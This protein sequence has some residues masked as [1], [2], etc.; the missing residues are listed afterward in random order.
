VADAA[1][2]AYNRAMLTIRVAQP[3]DRSFLLELMPRLADFS[4][5]AW[6]TVDEIAL[7]DQA[8][9]LDVLAAP[10]ADAAILVAVSDTGDRL[11]YLC[12]TTRRDYFTQR[13]HAHVEVLA[14]ARHAVGRGA[15]TTLMRAVEAWALEREYDCVTLNAFVGNARARGLYEHLGYEAETMHY[16]KML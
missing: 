4:L 2:R 3:D 10:R 8:L 15:G 7:A 6:R 13:L 9:V 12:A 1:A 16:R 11:G 5:P 14:V